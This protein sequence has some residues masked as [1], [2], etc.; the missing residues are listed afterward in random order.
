MPMRFRIKSWLNKELYKELL[1]FSDFISRNQGISIFELNE[2]KI[3]NNKYSPIDIIEKLKELEDVIVKEDLINIENYFKNQIGV[4]IEYDKKFII[5]KSKIFLKPY[6]EDFQIKGKYDNVHKFYRFEPYLY[7]DLKNYLI[8]KGLMVED[9][10]D[11]LN[12]KLPRQIK[13]NGELR[14]YQIDAIRSWE[15]NKYRGVIVLPTGSGKTVIAINAM[16]KLSVNTLVVVYTKEHIKQWEDSIKKFTDAG[17]MIG[18]FY[19]DEKNMLPITI[20]TYQ[21]AFR[22]IELFAKKFGLLIFDEAHHLPAEKFKLIATK[23]P[24]PFRMGL[25]ATAVREDGKHEE[26]FPLIG[27]IIYQKSPSDLSKEGY[28][29]PFI[30]RRIRVELSNED[31]KRYDELKNIYLNFSKGRS[32]NEVLDAAKKGEINAIKALRIRSQMQQIIQKSNSKIEKVVE[33]AKNELS[34]GSKIIIFTQY[35]DQ[36]EELANRLNAYLIHGGIEEKKRLETLY[37]FKNSPS[38][39]LVITTV[40]DEGLDI[41]DVNVGIFV[42]G[43]GSRR[44]FVQRLGRL[45]RPMP[46]KKSILYEIVASRTSEEAQSKKRRSGI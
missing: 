40:G 28:L 1:N 26:I 30:I 32:F 37:N 3:K 5:L 39:I 42:S 18:S 36:A 14:D 41:P 35:R 33:I 45:L 22:N 11:I 7:Y 23:M 15:N 38:G 8:S 19:G 16:S 46:G 24:S 21:S 17:G 12:N 6:L 4:T 10:T 9:K 20:T 25:S 34:K 27:G 13:F 44:Q 31:M 43:T 2:E 29:A